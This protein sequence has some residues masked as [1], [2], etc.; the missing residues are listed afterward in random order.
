MNVDACDKARRPGCSPSRL[1]VLW[2]AVCRVFKITAFILP[3]PSDA[4]AG[5]VRST[6]GRCCAIRS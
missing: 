5:D 4:F 2:E 1:F 6:G 3:A